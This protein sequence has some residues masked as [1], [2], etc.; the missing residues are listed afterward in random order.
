MALLYLSHAIWLASGT[1]F[2]EIHGKKPDFNSSTA[3]ELILFDK[4]YFKKKYNC[5]C[6]K[7]EATSS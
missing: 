6:F 1:A 7:V 4:G 5:G 2:T 3:L